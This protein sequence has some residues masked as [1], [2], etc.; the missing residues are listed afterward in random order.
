MGEVYEAVRVGDNQPA[1]V[2]LLHAHVLVQP[3]FV[4]R[5]VRE[6]RIVASLERPERRARARGRPG[7]RAACLTWRWSAW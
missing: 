6:A 1:A 4:Q 3:D 7:G 5:F 2:K